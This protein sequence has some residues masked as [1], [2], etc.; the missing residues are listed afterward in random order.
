MLRTPIPLLIPASDE[1]TSSD[2]LYPSQ[3]EGLSSELAD[4]LLQ[5]ASRKVLVGL[6]PSDVLM[7]EASEFFKTVAKKFYAL[8]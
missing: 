4:T 2:A 5:R 8:Y 7:V 3:P 1:A 6:T